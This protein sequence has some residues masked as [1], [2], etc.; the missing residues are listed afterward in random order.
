[1]HIRNNADPQA[2]V[3]ILPARLLTDHADWRQSITRAPRLPTTLDFC[4][5]NKLKATVTLE[6]ILQFATVA[7]IAEAIV[8]TLYFIRT[9]KVMTEVSN[10]PHTMAETRI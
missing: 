3:S 2:T 9:M 10:L 4:Q 8:E 7:S 6:K 5:S 1:M